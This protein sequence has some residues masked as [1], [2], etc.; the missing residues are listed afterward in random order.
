MTAEPSS[1]D[2][3]SSRF[4][5]ELVGVANRLDLAA[6]AA[7]ARRL[8][9]VRGAGGR[10]FCIGVGGG[11]ANAAHAV[12]DFRAMADMEAYAATDNTAT[13]TASIN[14]HGWSG[15][16]SRWLSGS[17][18]GNL[19]ALIVFSV[20]GGSQVPPVSLNVVEAIGLAKRRG[21]FVCGVVGPEGGETARSA[22]LCIRVPVVAADLITTHTEI[23]QA[24][25][26][27]LL[28]THPELNRAL[29]HWESL[30]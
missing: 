13:L 25:V 21:A 14:D 16:L 18:I 6:V 24:V 19:D 3:Y 12:C 23:F 15:S 27:H 11:A 7:L 8:R 30:R 2:A 10:L 22:D 29:P 26:W 9:E 5:A 17:R 28:V 20:G 4:V 1:V